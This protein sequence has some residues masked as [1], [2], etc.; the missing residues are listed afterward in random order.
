M[1][2]PMTTIELRE[3]MHTLGAKTHQE[4]ARMIGVERSSVSR[5]ATGRIPVPA[6]IA[7]LLRML[8]EQKRRA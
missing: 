2:K 1:I 6:Y 7:L 5:W 8:I 3:A 4:M